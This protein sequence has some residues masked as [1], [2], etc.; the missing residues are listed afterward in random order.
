MSSEFSEQLTGFGD[1]S[2][3]KEV[4]GWRE[5]RKEEKRNAGKGRSVVADGK[6]MSAS[7]VCTTDRIANKQGR[8]QYQPH[9]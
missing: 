4:E 7:T 2:E 9:F 1:R 3:G 5:G 6:S 8:R